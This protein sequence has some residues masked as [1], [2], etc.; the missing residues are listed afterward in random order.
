M[1]FL[2]FL[3][4]GTTTLSYAIIFIALI[5]GIT[6]RGG[7]SETNVLKNEIE[8]NMFFH[9]YLINEVLLRRRHSNKFREMNIYLKKTIFDIEIQNQKTEKFQEFSSKIQLKNSKCK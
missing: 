8:I 9:S 7:K 4:K 5:K 2:H 6:T 1:N 3:Q